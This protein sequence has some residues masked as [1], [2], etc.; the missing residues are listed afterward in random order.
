MVLLS[1]ITEDSIVEN[2]KKRY[3][4]DYIFTYIGSV[5]ISVNP[6]KQMP[7][8]GEKEIE[9]YQG[10]AQYENPPHIYALADSMYR[11]MIID[12][13]NQ[14]VIISGESGAGK[15]VA[16][17]YIMSYISKISG[18]G[19]KVQHVKDIILQSNPLLEAF[20]NAKT[21]RNNNSSRFGKYFE[22]QFSPGGEPDGGKISNFLL[23]KSRVVMRNPGERS[24]HIFYQLIEGASSEQKSVLGITSM[25]YYYY[26]NL[27]GS[28]KVD[29]INDKSDFQETLHAMSVIGIFGEEQNLVLQIVAG[30]L[31]L[32]NISFKEVGNY[33]AVES[34]EFLA[35]PAF[36]LGINQDRLKEKLTS[37]QMD[38]KW[39]GKSESIHV[40]LNVEQ[41]CY[42][43][44]AL[45][46]ALHSRV[47][48]YLVDS[49]NKA[50]EKD[51]E[52]YNIGVLD[53]YGFEIFQKNGFEQFCINF[54]NE[55]LQQIFI[56][57]TLKAEQEEYVQEGIRWTPIE[58]FNN[59]VVC[60]LI[61]NKVN[62]P[63][64]MSILDD[65][66][67]TMHAV[68]EGADQTL[69]QK[70]QMQIGTHEHFNSWNQGFI[71][72]HYAGKVSYD[73]DGFCERNR[74]VLFMDLIE[75]MQS[76]DLPFIKA[77]FPENLQVDKKGRPTTAGSK[78]KKQANDLVGTLM[79]CTPHY[80]R[81]IKPNETKKS[82]DWEESRV[83]HQVEY[84]GLKENI[85]VRRAGY[86]YRRVFK[87]FLQRYAILT[88]ATWP[89]WRGEEKQGVLHLLQ[90]VNMDP[91]Q[92]Q[93]GK[94]KVFIKAPE[95][96]FLLEEMRERKYDGYAR[97]I[98][99]AWRK[100]AARKRYVQMRE[101]A[102]DLLLN[103]KER[104]RNSLNRN[105]VGDYIGM[106]DHP[107]L[108]Q[109]VGKREKIDFADT[110]TKYDRR[111]KSVKRDLVLTP[112]CIYL[113]GREKVKQ[114]PEK[115]Q[116]KEVL[117]RRMEME[118]ILSVSL[119]T[120]Q[121]DIFILHEQ[122][123][124]SLLE[125]VFKTE[126]LSLLSKRY[127]EKTQR[128]L[129]LKF[130][131]TLEVKLKKESWGPWS[132]GG[133]R[134]VQFLQGQGD[135]ALLKPSNKVLQISIGPGLPKN[136]RPTRRNLTQSRGYSNRSQ[137]QT[138]PMRAAP[139]PPGQQ[140][141]GVINP[142]QSTAHPHVPGNQWA[143]Q[144]NLYTSMTRPALPRQTS[145]GSGRISQQPES[146]DF[147]KVPDQGA[148][149][150][151]RQTTNRPPP[152]GGRP[153]PQPKPKPQVPQ[154]RALY[155][156]DAQDTDELS[157]NA[158][159]VIDIIKEDPSGWWTGRLRGK[160]GLFPN[161]YVTKI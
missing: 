31:H 34:E 40:T 136:S 28:Y 93:L 48:D 104:R 98:Q 127:E 155:A 20:G 43:R 80:I 41:A 42:T 145:G 87:K 132:S 133:S 1:K 6:F 24:F 102:S 101:E 74:D 14:C 17:K 65:V 25:D 4:D 158:N 61:E 73:M 84:L 96:L 100:Y 53:I 157:F 5:L 70:L 67:A 146:L 120:M 140:Q 51:H 108:R 77:L 106:E 57:L 44:D 79:K 83:K 134:Q 92:Y 117:K 12:R 29:D 13:E 94:S 32:G 150:V 15:T 116:V 78:I 60:D 118:R 62:P 161:N 154:C 75:L 91:D 109:F 151:R 99:K 9:M 89:S 11:N 114:G 112:K 72:H 147:L 8:F 82:R 22:I 90:S 49:I 47:F 148:A 26:L 110:V 18:G 152:A 142:P 159:D 16:A 76:S 160:Q 86:A 36:L 97:A 7:Y 149:G 107:E 55:K 119:S 128:K 124:D 30:I 10:A 54:V 46:K 27:S 64:I 123:Y 2:L 71:I 52:E 113:I 58:Y 111:F 88:K 68:G 39:G 131:N 105:F 56:E 81:C 126:F 143:A 121:D 103:K 85:R 66:C 129:P 33:A 35:F 95:S 59:K 69:L 19:P 130:S 37:R 135:V 139:P 115:G 23:E 21:V 153:K 45:A 144:K 138:Y 122:E 137:S 38:S 3:M 156:Y 50:M 141:N 125:S 63:G